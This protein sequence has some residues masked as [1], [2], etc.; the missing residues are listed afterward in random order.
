MSKTSQLK[1]QN[2][3][4]AKAAR[5]SIGL[6]YK[7]NRHTQRDKANEHWFVWSRALKKKRATT[8]FSRN[9]KQKLLNK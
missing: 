6:K 7:E 3:I 8:E 9:T 5:K 1:K 4:R 2:S